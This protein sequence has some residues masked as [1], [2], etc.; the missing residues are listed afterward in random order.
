ML[1]LVMLLVSCD[2]AS[3]GVGAVV[4]VDVAYDGVGGV[5]VGGAVV[6]VG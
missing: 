4:V 3:V 6:V 2:V 5:V 1:L